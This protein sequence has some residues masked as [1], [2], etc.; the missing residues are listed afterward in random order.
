MEG[1]E[2]KLK[3]SCYSILNSSLSS[4]PFP[5]LS[6]DLSFQNSIMKKGLCRGRT[7]RSPKRSLTTLGFDYAPHSRVR[8]SLVSS[9]PFGRPLVACKSSTGQRTTFLGD[10]RQMGSTVLAV[11]T[12]YNSH[13]ISVE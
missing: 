6:E 4:D 10:G 12:K 13:P 11:H 7:S 8:G 2:S 9:P 5:F 1:I 3:F